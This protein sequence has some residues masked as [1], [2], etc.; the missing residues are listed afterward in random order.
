MFLNPRPPAG[1]ALKLV[2]HRQ[3]GVYL[4]Y[5]ALVAFVA[6]VSVPAFLHVGHAVVTVFASVRDTLS[7]PFP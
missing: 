6:L 4:E 2:A 5:L 3:G 1:T 7:L